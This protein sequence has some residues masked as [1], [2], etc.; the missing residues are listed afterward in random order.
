MFRYFFILLLTFLLPASQLTACEINIY[1]N[2]KMKPKAYTENGKAKGILIEMMDYVGADINCK[3]HYHFST[4]ARA[5]KNMLDLKGGVI[6]L[7]FTQ[8]RKDTIDF[9]DVMYNEEIL[10][11]TNINT[12]FTYNNLQDLS[13]KTVGASRDAKIGDKFERGIKEHVFTFIPDNGDPAHRLKRVAKRR[14]DVAIISPGLYAFNNVFIEH[15]E[16]IEIKEQLYILPKT[17]TVDP[18]YLGFSKKN[19]HKEFLKKF[20][21]SMKK[22]RSAGVFQAIEKKYHKSLSSYQ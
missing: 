22:A 7:S 17:F 4:W 16:L 18:N 15:P 8:S 6:G 21:L 14:L 11:V 3:F 10:L 13:G 19:D 5:Y 2:E 20:N 12:P 9:S 1:A